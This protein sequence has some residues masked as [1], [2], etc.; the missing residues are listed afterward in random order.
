MGR[1]LLLLQY[2]RRKESVG[3]GCIIDQLLEANCDIINSP[4]VD[5]LAYMYISMKICTFHKLRSNPYE[6]EL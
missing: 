4:D 2:E 3:L 6:T 5:T 1:K